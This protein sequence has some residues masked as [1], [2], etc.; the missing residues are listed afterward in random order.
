ME[1][2][3]QHVIAAADVAV[4]ELGGAQLQFLA[5]SELIGDDRMSVL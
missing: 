1:G 4:S 2:K 5:P 3:S